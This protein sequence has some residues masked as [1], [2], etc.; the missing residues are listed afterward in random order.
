MFSCCRGTLFNYVFYTLS[1]CT[2][3]NQKKREKLPY[4]IGQKKERKNRFG[5]TNKFMLSSTTRC[6][7]PRTDI[8]QCIKKPND[9]TTLFSSSFFAS[10]QERTVSMGR[11]FH[12]T[13]LKLRVRV[14][15]RVGVGQGAED[16]RRNCSQTSDCWGLVTVPDLSYPGDEKL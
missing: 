4:L 5:Y 10:R 1:L 16:E 6:D 11:S 3:P 13:R 14:D 9:R 15:R 12:C 8:A 2:K 7:Y